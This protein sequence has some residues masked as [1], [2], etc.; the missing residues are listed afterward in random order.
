[1]DICAEWKR[2]CALPV[3]RERMRDFGVREIPLML[4]WST[5]RDYVTGRAWPCCERVHLSLYVG[6]PRHEAQALMA[7][8][9]AHA[10]LPAREHHGE[11]WRRMFVLIVCE[12][13]HIGSPS[14][15]KA[16]QSRQEELHERIEGVLKWRDREEETA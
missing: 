16:K 3:V 7:H 13:W 11:A 4:A 2:L 8:E 12:G 1:M 15:F 5:S 9:L 6:C 14:Q 10:I